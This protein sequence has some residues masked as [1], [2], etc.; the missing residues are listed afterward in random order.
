V[1]RVLDIR[2]LTVVFQVPQQ[3]R[4]R[5]RPGLPAEIRFITGEVREGPVSFIATG[6]DPETRTFRAEVVIDNADG[7]IP[8]G[9][10]A[11]VR[12]PTDQAVGHFLS[13][14]ILSLGPDGALGVK[15]VTDDNRAAFHEV[16]I[17][18]AQTDGV[19][20]GGLPER[21]R[22]ITVGQGLVDAGEPV[23][24]R[25]ETDRAA[26]QAAGGGAP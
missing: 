6:A 14:A 20:V 5:L 22:I 11:Q 21:A 18:E 16:T 9:V 4:A 26:T 25:P 15:T 7:A 23:L 2:P 13:P 17:L 8:A 10:S 19:W 1:G 12:V 24:P 3:A